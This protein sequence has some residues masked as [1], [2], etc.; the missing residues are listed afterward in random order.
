MTTPIANSK[1][2]MPINPKIDKQSE[3]LKSCDAGGNDPS[4]DPFIRFKKQRSFS[5][6][7]TLFV[8][9]KAESAWIAQDA[10]YLPQI[11]QLKQEV[12]DLVISKAG[13]LLQLGTQDAKIEEQDK[14]INTLCVELDRAG[15]V[16]KAAR[17]IFYCD[18]GINY[19]ALKLFNEKLEEIYPIIAEKK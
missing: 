1:D 14:L 15:K 10:H 12:D 13:L 18:N 5:T 8:W 2:D 6:Q 7:C 11:Q 9:D 4:L 16:I 19:Q 17:H 3:K